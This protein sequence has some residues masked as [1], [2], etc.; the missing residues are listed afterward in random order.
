MAEPIPPDPR[1]Y[2]AAERTLL[3]WLRTGLTIMALGFVVA[4]FGLFLGLLHGQDLDSA[5]YGHGPSLYLGAGLV[6]L[7]VLATGVGGVGFRRYYRLLPRHD[8]PYPR[9]GLIPLGLTA[10]LILAGLLLVGL[11]LR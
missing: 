4:R 2:F 11:L 1:V 3:A 10:G 8:L 7:G 5:C 6:L 9:A